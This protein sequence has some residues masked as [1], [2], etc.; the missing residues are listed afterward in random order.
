MVPTLSPNILMALNYHRNSLTLSLLGGRFNDSIRLC[1]H[2][3]INFHAEFQR[4]SCSQCYSGTCCFCHW[5]DYDFMNHSCHLHIMSE[6][7]R[8]ISS[9]R[10]DN[11]PKN[12]QNYQ[13]TR[14]DP[15]FTSHNA[16]TGIGVLFMGKF[17]SVLV[18]HS[19]QFWLAV[20]Q[21][22]LI[23]SDWLIQENKI[24]TTPHPYT[25]PS[26]SG[27]P[28]LVSGHLWN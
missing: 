25:W 13:S 2:V 24:K 14:P 15:F 9:A 7:V 16:K 20:N 22:S 26:C 28:P 12:V 27:L 19:I 21:H 1:L 4:M 8:E 3:L 23:S 6:Y 5:R 18:L 11:F 17:T 10:V